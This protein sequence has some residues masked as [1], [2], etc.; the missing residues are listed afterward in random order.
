MQIKIRVI[1]NARQNKITADDDGN[2]KIYTTKSPSDGQANDAVVKQL[3]DYLKVPKLQIKIIRG[4][5]SR[6]KVI[7]FQD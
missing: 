1:P 7:T 5:T 4:I 6:D 3:S 2:L